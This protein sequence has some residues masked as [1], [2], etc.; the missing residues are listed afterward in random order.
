MYFAHVSDAFSNKAQQRSENSGGSMHRF[1]HV[2]MIILS[3]LIVL[4]MANAQSSGRGTLAGS[5]TDI[6]GGVIPGAKVTLSPSSQT[7]ATD[8][9]GDYYFSNLAAGEF[10][11]TVE[12]IGFQPYSKKVTIA[13]GQ[14]AHDTAALKVASN[15][16]KVEVFAG[17][18]KGEVESMN[19]QRSADNILQSLPTEVIQSLPNVNIADSVGR[20]PGVSLERDE[21]E[22]K[23]VQ[24]R[25]TEPRLSNL[26]INGVNIPAPEAAV[27]NIKLDTLPAAIVYSINVSKTLLPSMDGDG[28]GGSVDLV[29][30]TAT[31]KPFYEVSIMGGHTPII[32]NGASNV[33]QF[34]FGVGQRFG[35]TKRFGAYLG[36]SY[37][38]NGRGIDDIE[39]APAVGTLNG[40]PSQTNYALLYGTDFREY[41]YDRRRYGFGGTTDYQFA[42]G[43][44]LI[45]RGLFS[46]FQDY[47]GKY[48][49][50]P[51]IASFDTTT[52]S[53]DPGNQ[54]TYTNAPRNPDYLIANLSAS[55]NRAT[56][57]WYFNATAA[58]SRSRADNEDFPKADY[59]GPAGMTIAVDQTN[60]FRP[61]FNIMSYANPTD[62]IYDPT[63]YYLADTLITKDHSAQINLQGSF[64][65]TR[66]YSWNGHMGSWQ[67]G[68]KLR[69]AHKF[70][71]VNDNLYNY[72]GTATIADFQ[73]PYQNP[74]YYNGTY[75]YY[76]KGHVDNWG[77][78]MKYQAQNSGLFVQ[79]YS[80]CPVIPPTPANPC[81]YKSKNYNFDI[82]EM[83]PAQYFMNTIDIGRWR[84]VG[85][86]RIEETVSDFNYADH[87]DP[88]KSQGKVSS[89][90]VDFMP[91]FQVRYNFSTNTNIRAIYGRGVARPNYG[92]LVPTLNYNGTSH[93]VA[94]GNPKLLSTRANNFDLL[95]EHYFNTVGVVQGGFFFKQISNPIVTTT[96]LLTSG[97]YAGYKAAQ[98]IN[99]PNA[100]IGGLELNWEQHF[101]Q[102]PSYF[103]GLGIFANYGYSFSSAKFTWLDPNNV[104]QTETRDL[105]RQA[106]NTFNINPI[107][108][109]KHLSV[110][111]G[112]SYNEA[113][114]YA[115]NY[116]QIKG[117]TSIA[118]PKGP[119]GDVYFYSHLQY[120]TTIG[121][122]LPWGLK[123]SASGLNLNNEVF[124]FYQ[125]SSQ[126]PIQ[127][128]YYH[129]TYSFSLTW[130][131]E[132]EK[133]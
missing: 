76:T 113:N 89:T 53:T 62:N 77:L 13:A 79:D 114:I 88:T 122:L 83:I 121:Y 86:L 68:V 96:T 30:R 28:I 34:K 103:S 123:V 126:Y 57:P 20:L 47:G 93:Q 10:T 52:L 95:A 69:N 18:E 61:K 87:L 2:F 111:L 98:P 42:P 5:V 110:R 58:L 102:L 117:D 97:P 54:Y 94:E 74:N 1:K 16:E 24:I 104:Q 119:N 23:Y 60:P 14:V 38:Y 7:I 91:N 55:Y 4:Q 35:A 9:Q 115:Y 130:S 127:R 26:T 39:P 116:N 48:I 56:G 51:N 129:P 90:Y 99:L 43:S 107:F 59:N 70:D 25:S 41:H 64:D 3:A 67:A 22:G 6:A 21:G 120:D 92:D 125:G 80:T 40:D 19:L 15:V 78:L 49:Y 46:E 66:S 12:A 109:T 50:T 27:R 65:V 81:K 31:N 84:I 100:S 73:D 17:R 11:V 108:D 44:T 72:G 32:S 71:D 105:P 133:K 128:E 85:G 33:D 124:G 29:T 45:I 112:V 118:G 82:H 75:D 8:A 37:D 101:K 106:P 132:H 131:S 36:V 63:Q